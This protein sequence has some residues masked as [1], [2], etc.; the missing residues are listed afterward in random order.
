MENPPIFEFGKPSISMGHL[1]HGKALVITRGVNPIEIPWD[2]TNGPWNPSSISKSEASSSPEACEATGISCFCSKRSSQMCGK[3]TCRYQWILQY[4]CVR[5]KKIDTLE[6]K[7]IYLV[8]HWP[9]RTKSFTWMSSKCWSDTVSK[10]KSSL[11][12]VDLKM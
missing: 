10:Y 8:T 12:F 9:A 4:K 5:K 3:K 2:P 6:H 1:Y 7:L 11:R